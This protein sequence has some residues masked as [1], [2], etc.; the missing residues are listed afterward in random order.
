MNMI[1]KVMKYF[2]G[3]TTEVGGKAITWAVL[4]DDD[5]GTYSDSYEVRE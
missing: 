5:T 2:V 3:R 4:S 1:A